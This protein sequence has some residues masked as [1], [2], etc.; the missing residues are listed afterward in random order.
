MWQFDEPQ[1]GVLQ[2]RIDREGKPVNSFSIET[3][4]ALR[5]VAAFVEGRSD[6][7]AVVFISGKRGNFLAGADLYEIRANA[8]FD[9]TL[10]MSRNGHSA[11]QA[12]EE[13]DVMT[14]AAIHGVALGGG[15]EFALACDF[16]IATDDRKTLLGLPEVHLGLMPGWGATV[17]LPQLVGYELATDMLLSGRSLSPQESLD[18]GLVNEIVSADDLEK[19]A[20]RMAVSNPEKRTNPNFDSKEVLQQ[21]DKAE[22]E[23]QSSTNGEYPAPLEMIKVLREGLSED[24][25]KKFDLEANGIATL[26]PHPVTEELIRLFFLKE[27]AKKPPAEIK[28]A[29]KAFELKR[30]GVVGDNEYGESIAGLFAAAGVK[31]HLAFLGETNTDTATPSFDHLRRTADVYDLGDATVVIEAIIDDLDTERGLFQTLGTVVHPESTIASTSASFLVAE[32]SEGVP[33]PERLIGLRFFSPVEQT[34]LVEIVR[35]EDTNIESL[36]AAYAIARRL[37]RHT[38]L[39][40]DSPG[41]LVNRLL[42]PYLTELGYLMTELADSTAATAAALEFGMQNPLEITDILGLNVIS[43]IAKRMHRD[44]TEHYPPS[45]LWRSIMDSEESTMQFLQDG[46]LNPSVVAIVDRIQEDSAPVET[47]ESLVA[48]LIYPIIN[49][50]AQCLAEGVVDDA[51]AIDLAMVLGGGFPAFRGGP[52]RYAES[53]GLTTVVDELRGFARTNSRLAPSD[54]LVR[55]AEVGSFSS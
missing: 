28:E 20:M 42:V 34:S 46:Q 50:G 38:V 17:R 16:R 12:I 37:G 8:T 47:D 13:L 31:T 15:L 3:M 39:V 21:L 35:K 48:R 2:V 32:Q 49:A 36:A 9:A 7:Q 18:A 24:E 53:I 45:P 30:V 10:K 44:L 14:I 52:M 4:N 54:A 26:A 33:Q 22:A 1:D 41:F 40:K 29:A 25:E 43:A 6:I 19:A 11:F 23:V 27:A 55:F 5:D 51:D